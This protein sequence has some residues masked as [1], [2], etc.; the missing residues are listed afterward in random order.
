M[1]PNSP[2]IPI[3]NNTAHPV[4]SS[5]SLIKPSHMNN[6]LFDTGN[7]KKE[8]TWKKIVGI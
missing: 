5:L 4:I 8:K 6:N 3:S 1:N 2:G 7:K